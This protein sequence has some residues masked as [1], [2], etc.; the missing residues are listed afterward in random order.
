MKVFD[1]LS[2]ESFENKQS[3]MNEATNRERRFV[4]LFSIVLR[5]CHR[6]VRTTVNETKINSLVHSVRVKGRGSTRHAQ[7]RGSE[8]DTQKSIYLTTLT[9][10]NFC[11]EETHYSNNAYR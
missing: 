8:G 10:R 1:S 2:N 6:R 3:L 7:V 9:C 11:F 4:L 5:Y